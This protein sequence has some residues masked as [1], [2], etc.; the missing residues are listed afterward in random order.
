MGL[1]RVGVL[2]VSWARGL[3]EMESGEAQGLLWALLDL[4][5]AGRSAHVQGGHPTEPQLPGAP[6]VSSPRCEQMRATW[7][8]REGQPCGTALPQPCSKDN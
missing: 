8:G 5:R 7:W 2:S 3:L 4:L 1:W 6:G